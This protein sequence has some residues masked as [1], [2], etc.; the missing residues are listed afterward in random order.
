M[1]VRRLLLTAVLA[2]ACGLSP[3]LAAPQIQGNRVAVAAPD[4]QGYLY[5]NFPRTEQALGGLLSLTISEPNVDLPPG[6]RMALAFDLALATLGGAPVPVGNV[7]LTSGLRYDANTQGFHLEQP[8]IDGFRPATPGAQ[9]DPR[10]RG[11]LNAWLADYARQEP[12][13]RIDPTLGQLLGALQVR[14]ARVENGK[15]VLEFNQDLDKLGPAYL[16]DE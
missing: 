14:S 13:Y 5:G 12:V 4:V 10:A 7:Q 2:A 16:L 9:L 15:V 6:N 3:V 1:P 8:S 11:L